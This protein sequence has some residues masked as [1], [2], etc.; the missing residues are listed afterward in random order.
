MSKRSGAEGGDGKLSGPEPTG[1]VEAVLQDV[2]GAEVD[3][4]TSFRGEDLNADW[5]DGEEGPLVLRLCCC[6]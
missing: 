5:G 2:G 6:A 1:G 3:D 4:L